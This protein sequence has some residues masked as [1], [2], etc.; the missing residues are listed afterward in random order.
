VSYQAS[1]PNNTVAIG[2]NVKYAR[3]QHWGLT[4]SGT[5]FNY[6]DPRAERLWLLKTM[7]RNRQRILVIIRDTMRG[8]TLRGD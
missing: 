1:A 5:P 4:K 7:K 8:K 3:R 2:T 6:V